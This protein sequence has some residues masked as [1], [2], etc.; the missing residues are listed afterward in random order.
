MGV[1]MSTPS[2][3]IDAA[4]RPLETVAR[5]WR[6]GQ[7]Q[8]IAEVASRERRL[9]LEYP[10]GGCTLWTWPQNMSP[11]ALGHVQLD[12]L[13]QGPDNAPAVLRTGAVNIQPG[14]GED[15]TAR[16]SLDERLEAPPAHP[17]QTECGRAPAARICE[18]MEK[19]MTLPGMWDGTGCFHRAALVRPDTGEVAFLSEDIGRHNCVDRLIGQCCL[20]GEAP[21]RYTLFISARI[22]ASLYNKARR[23]GLACMVSRAAVTSASLNS[24]REQGVTLVGFCRPAE[25][26]CT[27]F[28]DAAQR[29]LP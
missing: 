25:D 17:A 18:C 22:T 21:W 1:L 6:R 10:G 16:L 20:R 27:I 9:H 28:S 13:H 4:A 29:I 7:W 23:A 26:R 12:C 24:A 8:D 14:P 3:N 11:L 2:H 15:F 5:Q 19:V